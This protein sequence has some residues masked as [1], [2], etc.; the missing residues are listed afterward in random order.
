MLANK[1]LSPTI[2]EIIPMKDAVMAIDRIARRG[3][4]G[5]VVFIND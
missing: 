1:S 4:V 5:K 3:V 2:S